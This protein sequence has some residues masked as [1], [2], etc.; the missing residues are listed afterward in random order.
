MHD[1]EF[2]IDNT[3]SQFEK[4]N[5]KKLSVTPIVLKFPAFAFLH[6]IMKKFDNE[7][8]VKKKN[9][10]FQVRVFSNYRSLP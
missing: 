5:I 6:V 4:T 10:C 3:T 8:I 7:N 9:C 2:Q 1:I